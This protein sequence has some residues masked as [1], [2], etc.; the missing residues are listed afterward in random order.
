MVENG[1]KIRKSFNNQLKFI[2]IFEY[3]N[4]DVRLEFKT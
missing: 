3:F 4:R 1:A 2:L